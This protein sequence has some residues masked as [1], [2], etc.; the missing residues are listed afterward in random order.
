[1]STIKMYGTSWCKDCIRARAYLDEHGIGYAWT[2]VD[3]ETEFVSLIKGLNNGTQRVP[4][5]LFPD[6]SVLIEP[7]NEQLKM[8]LGL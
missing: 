1:M 6:G 3:E 8:K 5:I 7:S 4:T 2:D